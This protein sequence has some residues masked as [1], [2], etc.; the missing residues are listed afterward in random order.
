MSA[1]LSPATEA[2]RHDLVR[3]GRRYFELGWL[4]A[5]AGN[6][7]ARVGDRVVITASGKHKGELAERDFVEVDL[8][9]ALLAAGHPGGKASA[10][11][12]I[13]LAIYRARPSAAVALHVHT[14][15]STLVHGR[16]Y[17]D[18]ATAIPV[19]RYQGVEMVKAWDLWDEGLTVDLPVFPNHADVPQIGRDVAR[20]L[21]EL[22]ASAPIVPALLVAGHGITAWGS[23]AFTA[24]R[25]VEATEF[26]C[27]LELARSSR[28]PSD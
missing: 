27:R 24:N 12:S 16:A 22:P 14:V 9:G 10:E 18:A 21:A 15:A 11:T 8:D 20:H 7:S 25:H 5:T 19:V 13:H 17:A 26:L 6:L 4:F 23:D 2:A 3:L 28:S 1:Q